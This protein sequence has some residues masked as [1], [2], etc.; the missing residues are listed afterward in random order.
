MSLFWERKLEKLVAG[1]LEGA[2]EGY[3][4]EAVRNTLGIF[5]ISKSMK[6]KK[7]I[8]NPVPKKPLNKRK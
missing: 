2:K 7:M 4:L 6:K 5:L 8:H 3:I 1:I